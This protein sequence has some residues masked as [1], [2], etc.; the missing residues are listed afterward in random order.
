[1]FNRGLSIFRETEELVPV[2]V[3]HSYCSHGH[4][5]ANNAVQAEDSL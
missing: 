4:T 2:R 3:T 1:M 5:Q